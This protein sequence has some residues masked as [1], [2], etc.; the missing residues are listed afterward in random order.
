ME[1]TGDTWLT[2]LQH[3]AKEADNDA[4]NDATHC[5]KAGNPLFVR[6]PKGGRFEMW[7]VQIFYLFFYQQR[8]F[9]SIVPQELFC[10]NNVPN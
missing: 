10:S 1:R 4:L 5:E 7:C 8:V 6:I 3:K 9:Y 2:V